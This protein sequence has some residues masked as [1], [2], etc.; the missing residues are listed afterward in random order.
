[1]ER[2]KTLSIS[3]T[4]YIPSGVRCLRHSVA[5]PGGVVETITKDD[6]MMVDCLSAEENKVCM[7]FG[8]ES[9]HSPRSCQMRGG[10]EVHGASV[11][12]DSYSGGVDVG[13]EGV[14]NE[15]ERGCGNIAPFEDVVP[16]LRESTCGVY[17]VVLCVRMCMYSGS[18]CDVTASLDVMSTAGVKIVAAGCVRMEDI[19]NGGK[20]VDE[21]EMSSLMEES[22]RGMFCLIYV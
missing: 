22:I 17:I 7:I 18:T 6:L 21:E 4:P 20:L 3:R 11:L 8:C 13:V 12:D 5:F 10:S 14:I 2:E 15:D 1:M 9:T 16:I 19:D